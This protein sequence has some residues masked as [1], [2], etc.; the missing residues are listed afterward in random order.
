MTRFPLKNIPHSIRT[1]F[2]L[3]TAGILLSLLLI[4]YLGGRYILINIIR[5]AEKEI[6]NVSSDIKK[7]IT[8]QSTSL[9]NFTVATAGKS[10]EL[11]S[12]KQYSEILKKS[13][14]PMRRRIRTHISAFFAPDGSLSDGYY[15]GEDNTCKQIEPEMLSRYF[16]N[17]T[18]PKTLL[19]NRTKPISGV[20]RFRNSP[21]Y[22]SIVPVHDSNGRI[23]GFLCIGSLVQG[24]LL[25]RK[26]SEI[27]Q[28]LSIYMK[29]KPDIRQG[30]KSN[31]LDNTG[32]PASIFTDDKLF[33]AGSKWH[34]GSNEFEAVIPIFD[35]L[36]NEISSL[37]IRFPRS[38]SSLTKTALVWLTAFVAAV[39]IIFIAPIFWLQGRVILDPLTKLERQ[40]H[41]IAE[42]YR[43]NK[44]EYLNYVSNDE[45]GS[46]AHSV[47]RLLRELNGKSLEIL[48]HAQRNNALVNSIADCLCIFNAEAELVSIE[49]EPDDTAPIP[50]L[51]KNGK[52][53]PAFFYKESIEQFEQAL[54]E[55]LKTGKAAT[56]SLRG[57]QQKGFPRYFEARINRMD[58]DFVLVVFRDITQEHI[59][60]Q[61]KKKIESRTDKIRQMSTMGNL[62]ASIAHDFN[63]I[64]SIITNTMNIKFRPEDRCSTEEKEAVNAIREASRRG[65][66]L[67]QELIACAGQ[68]RINLE[69]KNPF[70]IINRLTPLYKGLIPP[71]INLDISHGENLHDVMI[72]RTQFWKVIVNLVKNA[73]ESIKGTRGYIRISTF[74]YD[75]TKANATKFLSSHPLEADK[76]VIFEV[77]DNGP[78]I[79]KEIRD[80]LFEPFFSTKKI[81]RG[82]GLATVFGI[83]DSHNGGINIISH[84]NVG[85]K[86]RIWLPAAKDSVKNEDNGKLPEQYGNN[87]PKEREKRKSNSDKSHVLVID[88]DPSI[89][90]TT[91]LLIEHL[92]FQTLTAQSGAEAFARFRKYKNEIDLVML[93]AQL[94]NL[95]SVRLLSTLRRN[96]DNIPVII[97][98]GHSREK[99]EQMFSESSI[100][101]ILTKPYTVEELKEL[102]VSLTELKKH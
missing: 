38:F 55:V 52:L 48:S 72:D 9:M 99:I 64:L 53:T 20:I 90:R 25:F 68:A 70:D 28:G 50:D 14:N 34:I 11:A 37:S 13:I 59:D 63:N 16:N 42:K 54:K 102:L 44:I 5:Q 45:F 95:D 32:I 79:P 49:K 76:G 93:D 92:G 101:G 96:E 41:E 27:S 56:A 91:T 98:S 3:L 46:L 73:A 15:I 71:N 24:D 58:E 35:I 39:G 1:H 81:N 86:F 78:G 29:D 10:A 83:V 97:C 84:E 88:D 60:K 61:K 62:A 18:I 57:S 77:S 6:T 7:L 69:R 21:Y 33:G 40:I 43:E 94:G 26:M 87:N 17:E 100:D 8:Y 2:G 31:E 47:N 85:T 89:I 4:F 65:S 67:V 80:R 12:E 19:K 66:E 51:E 23:S 82:L 22:A 36:G 75:L 30:G 74:N